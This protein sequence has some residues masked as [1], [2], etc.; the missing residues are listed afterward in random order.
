MTEPTILAATGFVQLVRGARSR[1][2]L[3]A[4]FVSTG[5]VSE[6]ISQHISWSS[7]IAWA[8]QRPESHRGEQTWELYANPC[9]LGGGAVEIP[10]LHATGEAA[11]TRW[12]RFL[13]EA[14]LRLV[15]QRPDDSTAAAP[16]SDSL[17]GSSGLLEEDR[18]DHCRLPIDECLTDPCEL[19]IDPTGCIG[20]C[21][22]HPS[23]SRTTP[24][25]PN[26][27]L[28]PARCRRWPTSPATMASSAST[29]TP[30]RSPTP[31]TRPTSSDSPPERSATPTPS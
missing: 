10:P 15:D 13:S 9:F 16:G 25:S 4:K 21:G 30:S 6:K 19:K 2:A 17:T 12:L 8:V 29:A 31:V 18:C 14:W 7:H 20:S 22:D 5:P 11:A 27:N 24:Y 23:T 1:P 28:N 26:T 3:D